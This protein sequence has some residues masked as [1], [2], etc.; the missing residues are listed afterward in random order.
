MDVLNDCVS[1]ESRFLAYLTSDQLTALQGTVARIAEET[2][3]ARIVCFG[4]RTTHIFCSSSFLTAS[5]EVRTMQ[6]DIVILTRENE[7]TKRDK[8]AEIVA[9]HNDVALRF[10][11]LVH[12]VDTVDIKLKEGH[13]FFSTLFEKGEVLFQKPTFPLSVPAQRVPTS[14]SFIEDYWT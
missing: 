4:I 14:L 10:F 1:G 13:L 5:D 3:A 8:I 11:V 2:N 12:G 7:K 9:K 6:C